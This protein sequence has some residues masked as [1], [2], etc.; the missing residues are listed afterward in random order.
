MKKTIHTLTLSLLILIAANSN[1]QSVSYSYVRNNPYDIKNLSFSIDP[2]FV[3][4]NAHNGYSFGWGARME[5]MMGKRLLVNFDIKTGFGTNGYRKS[6]KTPV[7]ILIWKA[8][9]V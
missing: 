6:T 5:H 4:I 1:A 3:D 7:T 2:M 8:V 9:L